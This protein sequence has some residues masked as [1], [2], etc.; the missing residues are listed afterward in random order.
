MESGEEGGGGK[1]QEG[2]K[3]GRSR[4]AR[5]KK[6]AGKKEAR[7]NRE[8]VWRGGEEELPLNVA[9]AQKFPSL[10]PGSFLVCPHPPT[11]FPHES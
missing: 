10:S 2:E 1:E 8:R 7:Y 9:G 4:R 5:K 11:H 6:G 3:E